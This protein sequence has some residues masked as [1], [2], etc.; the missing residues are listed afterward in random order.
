MVDAST[1][2]GT[3]AACVL[4]SERSLVA[5]LA[6]ANNYKADHLRQPENWAA[7]EAS[8]VIYSAGFF[9]TGGWGGRALCRHLFRCWCVA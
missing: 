6:A 1:P 2:T 4:D 7:V 3:C 5:N 8:R 9:I